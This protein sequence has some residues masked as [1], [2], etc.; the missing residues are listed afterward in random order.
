MSLNSIF[1]R[2]SVSLLLATLICSLAPFSSA[3]AALYLPLVFETSIPLAGV[4]GRIDHM[5]V[6]LGRKRLLV[7]ELGN[8]SVDV[9][10]LATN[11]AI[12]RI[13]GL[14]NP[15]G[16]AFAPAA[17]L[18]LIANAGDGSVRMFGGAD[19]SE[20]GKIDLGDDADNIRID[21]RN[22][23]A[24]VGYGKGGL[25]FIDPARRSKLAGIP[26]PAHPES[27]QLAPASGRIFV[28]L[29]DARQIAVLDAAAG[30]QTATWTVPEA[31]SNFPMAVDESL[32]LLAAVYRN[33]AQLV[34]FDLTTGAATAKLETCGDS[35]DLFFDDKFQRIYV[36]WG[37]GV[38]DVFQRQSSGFARLAKMATVPGARTSLFVPEL[39][40]L[41]VAVR[42]AGD[43]PASIWIFRPDP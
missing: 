18:I 17:D 38:I 35:D 12:H 10:D 9:I 37:E 14:R 36:S 24:I 25:A 27:F 26:L 29:P 23:Q 34:L 21:P 39:D 3:A 8:D 30:K 32:G 15:Q 4:A 6:D 19:F 22:G 16:V 1:V 41:Y 2:R 40:R 5:A 43:K 42:A 33:P 31:R 20:A 7:A 13:E 28:N 11:K